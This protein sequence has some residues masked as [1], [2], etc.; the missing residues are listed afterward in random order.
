LVEI[1]DLAVVVSAIGWLTPR[2]LRFTT[3]GAAAQVEPAGWAVPAP[4]SRS[5]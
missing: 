3:P 1:D 5:T 2:R 4:S